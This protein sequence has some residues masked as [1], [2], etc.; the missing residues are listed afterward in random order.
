MDYAI[1][2]LLSAWYDTPVDKPPFVLP[3]DRSHL[4]NT[5]SSVVYGSW[6]EYQQNGLEN[7]FNDSRLHLGLLP[8]PW[9]GDPRRATVFVLMLNPGLNPCDYFADYKVRDYRNALI[10]NLRNTECRKYPLLFLDPAFS[11]TSG[12]RYFRN[13]LLWLV[14]AMRDQRRISFQKSLQTVA[15]QVCILQLI[16]YHSRVFNDTKCLFKLKSVELMRQFVADNLSVRSDVLL[17]VTRKAR[18][19]GLLKEENHRIVIYWGSETRGAH[20]SMNTRGGK[21]IARHL[22]LT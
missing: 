12:A 4:P 3:Q 19:W 9:F 5:K 1:K 14:E 6:N 20:L 21:A 8:Q 11:W 17:V 16:P 18:K 7:H 15:K 22:G 13:R 2:T 10:Q